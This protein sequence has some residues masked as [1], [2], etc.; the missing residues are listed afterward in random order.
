MKNEVK[1]CC[2]K[3]MRVFGEGEAIITDGSFYY[4]T[5]CIRGE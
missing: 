3:C 1:K 5:D 4:H 2:V